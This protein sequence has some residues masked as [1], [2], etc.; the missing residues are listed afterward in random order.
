MRRA[1]KY[2]IIDQLKAKHPIT[3]LCGYLDV[4]RSAY[5]KWCHNGKPMYR[6][7]DHSL[8]E[9]IKDIF[10]ERQ[11]GYRFITFELKRRYGLI[12]NRK[13]TL[14]YMRILG[15][16]SPIRKRRFE[17]ATIRE[18]DEKA[19]TV[20][21]NVLARDFVASRPNEKL[22]TDVTYVYHQKGRMYLSVIKDLFDNSI[23]AYNV[24]RWNDINLVLNTIYPVFNDG[25][26]STEP[27]IL[28]SDQGFQY[29]SRIYVTY[30]ESHGVTV[31]H[32][33]K[34][35][36]YDNACCENFFSHLKSECLEREIP[37]DEEDLI[38]KIEEYIIWYNT[39]RP[40]EKLKGMTP[41]E[42]RL[43]YLKIA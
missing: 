4:N 30:L 1:E 37:K 23:I 21:P 42:Y 12:I 5:Y 31:S 40:E 3:D 14:R 11:K 38:K 39:N 10:D 15:L 33:R 29:T 35:N 28:H 34:G 13:T 18:V 26:D 19:R 16:K 25:W 36:V 2:F 24:S 20:K 17:C 32:S 22:V 43:S 8:A 41:M 9:F 6:K 7:F 27:C